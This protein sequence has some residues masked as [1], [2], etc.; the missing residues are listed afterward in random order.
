MWRFKLRGII[1]F[2]IFWILL[3]NKV[4]KEVFNNLENGD[5]DMREMILKQLAFKMGEKELEEWIK[6]SDMPDEFKKKIMQDLNRLLG[7]REMK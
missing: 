2:W 7:K 1:F 3:L 6:N 5:E 4:M